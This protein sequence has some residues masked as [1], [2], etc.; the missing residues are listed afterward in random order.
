[1]T[2]KRLSG[3][4]VKVLT[5]FIAEPQQWFDGNTVERKTELPA[6]S[7]RHFLYSFF[8][9]GL[10]ERFEAHRGYRYR[11]SAS[12]ESQPYFRRVLEAAEVIRE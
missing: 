5:V 1:M 8:K 7:I 3:E 4:Q 9:L 11:L 12:A 10:L 6:S 2:G